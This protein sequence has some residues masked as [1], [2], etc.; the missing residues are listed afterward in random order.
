MTSHDGPSLLGRRRSRHRD[1][2]G[3]YGKYFSPNVIFL[4]LGRRRDGYFL[5]REIRTL[6]TSFRLR[7]LD[8]YNLSDRFNLE[9]KEFC[10]A[11]LSNFGERNE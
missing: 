10:D 3:K 9:T 6:V 8:R 5:S 1:I 11:A 4:T 2:I 7:P